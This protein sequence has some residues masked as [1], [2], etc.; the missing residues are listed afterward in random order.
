MENFKKILN[1]VLLN[2]SVLA[3]Q[4][5][6]AMIVELANKKIVEFWGN[7][8]KELANVLHLKGG[9]LTIS[10]ANSIMAQ[11]IKFKQMRLI[12]A[13]NS[14]F[15]NQAAKQVKIVQKGIEVKEIL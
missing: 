13:I 6:A 3:R 10:C 9:V 7:K 4:V 5:R 1:N 8:A 14:K 2:K 12:E 15:G 11:E